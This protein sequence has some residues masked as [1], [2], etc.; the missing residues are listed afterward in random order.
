MN[1]VDCIDMLICLLD[2]SLLVVQVVNTLRHKMLR[3]EDIANL[4]LQFQEKMS[5]DINYSDIN[6]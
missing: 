4:S 6:N 1:V 3:E 5:L 2:S